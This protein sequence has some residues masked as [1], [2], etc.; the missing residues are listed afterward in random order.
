MAGEVRRFQDEDVCSSRAIPPERHQDCRACACIARCQVG[1]AARCEW[2]GTFSRAISPAECGRS[3]VRNAFYCLF[4][5]ALALALSV[6][7][8]F[9]QW[10]AR[11]IGCAEAS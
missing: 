8:R 10:L 6:V 2:A 4:P 9:F 7:R 1:T 3:V 11:E 5:G